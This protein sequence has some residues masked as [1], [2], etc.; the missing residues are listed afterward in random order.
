MTA[1]Q[2]ATLV[3]KAAELAEAAHGAINHVRK[4]TG[5]PYTEHLRAVAEMVAEVGGTDEMVAAAWLHDVLEDTPTTK[6][7]LEAA[8]GPIVT[9]YVIELTDVSKPADGNRAR[10]KAMDKQHLAL[11]SAEAQTIKLADLINNAHSIIKFDARF[12]I[13]FVEESRQLLQA[14]TKGHPDLRERVNKL[15]DGFVAGRLA[16]DG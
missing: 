16:R 15:V 2:Q 3:A 6:E 12:S 10:R 7:K 8:V 1:S 9:Q 5:E 11:A 14:M 4:Y 13:V